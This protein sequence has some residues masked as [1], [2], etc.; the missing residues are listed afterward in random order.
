MVGSGFYLS[1]VGGGALRPAGDPD[2]DRDGHRRHLPRAHL[3]APGAR[4]RRSPA[5]PMRTRVWPM[6][7]S[8]A[9][10]SRGATGSRSGP[11]CRSI[12]FAF[13]G[14]LMNMMPQLQQQGDGADAHDRRDLGGGARSTCAASRRRGG[15]FAE[16]T[17]YSKLVPFAAIARDRAVLR[18]RREPVPSSTP[19]AKSLLSSLRRAGAAD[20][21]RLPRAGVGHGAGGRRAR[22]DAHDSRA[23][24]IGISIAALLYVLGTVVVLGVVPREQLVQVDRAVQRRGATDVGTPGAAVAVAIAVILSSIGAL[25]GWTLLMGQVPMA[26][27]QDRLVSG[28]L[29]ARCRGAACRPRHR[30]LGRAG[31]RAGGSCR[32]WARRACVPFY[33]L[34]VSLST[35]AAVIPYAFCALALG[36]IAARRVREAR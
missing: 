9:F 32:R 7:T 16:V 13:A 29:R 2:V 10:S 19:A 25:N 35:M 24:I 23:T 6:A 27:A 20:D 22:P 5:A 14:A 1:P 12:A 4:S 11:R 30:V 15:L 28:G 36:L 3:R 17:T 26:A 21:V 8:P 33:N 18:A 31:H 34:V